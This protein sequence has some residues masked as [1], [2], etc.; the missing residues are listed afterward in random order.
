MSCIVTPCFNVKHFPDGLYPLYHRIPKVT[1]HSDCSGD[2]IVW[3]PD[4]V[5]TAHI[6]KKLLRLEK[7]D[8]RAHEKD[9][10]ENLCCI[11]GA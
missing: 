3:M 7:S 11:R 6:K 8:N 2:T 9:Q 10:R 5:H 4:C 1:D